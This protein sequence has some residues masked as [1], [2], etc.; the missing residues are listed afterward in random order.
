MTAIPSSVI[1]EDIQNLSA[2]HVQSAEGMI[3]LD[4][5][6]NPFAL[7]EPLR[8][9]IALRISEVGVNRY[10]NP[11]APVLQDMLRACMGIPGDARVLLG[12]GSDELLQIMLTACAKP[13][14]VV[15]TLS[16]GFVMYRMYSLFLGLKFVEVSLESDFSLDAGK[17]I[18]VMREARP[19]VV[20][21]AYPN[22]PTGNGFDEDDLVSIIRQAPGLVVIDEAYQPFASGSFLS[23]VEEFQ[24]LVVLRTL[25]KLGLAGIRLGYAVGRPDWIVQF[26]KVR[27]PYNVNSLTQCYAEC[28]LENYSVL[29]QQADLICVERTSLLQRLAGISGVTTFPSDANFLAIRVPSASRLFEALKGRGILVK[30][31]DGAHPILRDC[32]RITVGT[33]AENNSLVSAI[34]GILGGH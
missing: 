17:F 13:G 14:A 22:N 30:N 34:S 20:F 27:S 29:R 12:N 2:Y 18:K 33:P 4:A 6:E 26:D 11:S 8:K 31:L 21:I 32:L 7:P 23:R 24:N 15:L 25:S 3:K 28:V 9:A 16:P 10:P 1:R 5:M 19:A